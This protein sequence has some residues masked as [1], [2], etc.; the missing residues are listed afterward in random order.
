MRGVVSRSALHH[1]ADSCI[2][3]THMFSGFIEIAMNRL[4]LNDHRTDWECGGVCAESL[5]C[6]LIHVNQNASISMRTK[7]DT[8]GIYLLF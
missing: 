4:L 6:E 3:L 1:S 7:L 2:R 8:G 5:R